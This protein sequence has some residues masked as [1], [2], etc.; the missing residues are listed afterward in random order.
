M[1]HLT[2][3]K[4]VGDYFNTN[5][6]PDTNVNASVDNTDFIERQYTADGLSEFISFAIKIRMQGTNTS[7]VPRVKDL[8]AI[9]L[10]T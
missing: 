3:M 4:L 8:R 9:A 6:S 1:M 2:S 5:G 10:A 7:E